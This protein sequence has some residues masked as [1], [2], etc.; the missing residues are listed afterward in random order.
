MKKS[1]FTESPIAAIL[2]KGKPGSR[3]PNRKHGSTAEG[4]GSRSL[5]A[6]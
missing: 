3:Q 1:R 2:K 5:I 4:V 6:H